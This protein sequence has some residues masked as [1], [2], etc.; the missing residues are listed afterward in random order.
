VDLQVEAGELVLLTGPTGCGKS[1]LLRLLAGLLQ[2]HGHG[3]T[4]GVIRVLGRDPAGLIAAERARTLGFVGQDP[5]DAVVTGSCAAEIAFAAESA[6]L[7]VGQIEARVRTLLPRVGLAGLGD[8]A[9]SALSGGQRQ[10]LVIG[11]ALAAGARVL[12][13]DEPLSQLDPRGAREVLALLRG[14]ADEGVAVICVEH[15]LELAMP[16]AT[17]T[18]LMVDGRVVA[19]PVL[20]GRMLRTHGLHGPALDELRE[21][22]NT[23]AWRRSPAAAGVARAAATTA[24]GAPLLSASNLRFAWPDAPPSVDGVSLDVR[25]G[26][27]VA[28]VGA[29]GAG[30][31]TLL[32]V[33]SGRLRPS[34]GSVRVA[35]RL[36]EVPQN[37]DLSLFCERVDDELAYGP[38]EAR[39]GEEPTAERVA[40]AASA[41]SVRDLVARPPQALSRGQR[42]RTAVAAAVTCAPTVLV[43]DEP[44]SGQDRDQVDR[45]LDALPRILPEGAVLF[46]SHDVDVV[47]R[48]ATRVV[49]LDTGRVVSDGPPLTTLAAAEARGLPLDLP[50]LARLCAALGLP[51]GTPEQVA[52]WL[53][54]GPGV[55][56]AAEALA[57]SPSAEAREPIAAAGAAPS[58]P[59]PADAP[60]PTQPTAP[61]RPA[62]DPRTRLGLVAILGVL[63]LCLEG[64][65]P[66]AVLAA[67]THAG[68]LLHPSTAGWRLRILGG[69]ALLAWST[70]LSQGLFWND[71]P[72]TPLLVLWPEVG[73]QITREGL[74]HGLVQSLRFLS[75][76]AAGIWVALSTPADRLLA[77]L[78]A[79][80]VPFG[81]AL[82]GSTAL[83]FVPLVGSELLAVRA[84]RAH[85]GRPAWARS[86]W[87][88][89]HL[90]VDLLRPVVA[91]SL[92]RARALA[93]SLETRGFHP[94]APRAI[95]DPLR[96]R[97]LDFA[98]L[99]SAGALTT[100]VASA[101]L[102][103][104]AYGA[105]L[106]YAPALRPLY[107]FVRTWL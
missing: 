95:R 13:L 26:E 28:L 74:T 99:A 44:T 40:T 92:R 71:W 36:V 14:L 102:L 64:A 77:A 97:G 7:A 11:A 96:L 100:F 55:G 89:A 21:H 58:G 98:A 10:R 18:V 106:Y 88:W 19:D 67:V 69:A 8:R 41:L 62:L 61:A 83:R 103:F 82:M 6:G 78:L 25:A 86:P 5:D 43:L 32:G 59:P 29:N 85:R 79:L 38:R 15:R 27:R 4:H 87:A 73:V 68:L 23:M 80:R 16:V 42:L 91:R 53:E 17:R 39:L 2:R 20:D 37:P 104:A 81:V 65:V 50:P 54:A 72:R 3:R 56:Q 48:H 52:A 49:V 93:E 107:A 60:A 12:L 9:P 105:E 31:S 70:A 66:L 57:A 75:L 46:A 22:T 84:A 33:L 94:T 34:S 63:V 76:S 24:G 45:M 101:R 1:T 30:K 51:Y 47:L 90:E 35:G